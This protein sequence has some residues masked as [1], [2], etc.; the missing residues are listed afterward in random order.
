MSEI[1]FPF[2]PLYL[3]G[4]LPT[5]FVP[6]LGGLLSGAMSQ[7]G[8]L[9]QGNADRVFRDRVLNA[10][11]QLAQQQNALAQQSLNQRNKLLEGLTNALMQPKPS[12]PAFVFPGQGPSF[13][14]AAPAPQRPSGTV[15]PRSW[16]TG[17]RPRAFGA[18][19]PPQAPGQQ[20]WVA[21]ASPLGQATWRGPDLDAAM[22][23]Q[24]Q[25]GANIYSRTLPGLAQGAFGY[26]PVRNIQ[27]A[28]P[29]GPEM[30]LTV[31]A[32][33]GV[34]PMAGMGQATVQGGPLIR[35]TQFWGPSQDAALR[36]R[37]AAMSNYTMPF[38][39]GSSGLAQNF[40]DF[41]AGQQAK[42]YA[43]VSR[44]GTQAQAK[45]DLAAATANQK[46]TEDLWQILNSLYAL[47]LEQDLRD[48]MLA[49]NMLSRLV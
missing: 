9:L 15:R 16:L 30:A 20:T 34:A 39:K 23:Q 2:A 3:S 14:S 13:P 17:S 10:Q 36:A 7:M 26:Q 19:S 40:R 31:G 47:E 43:D 48:K 44:Q 24:E 33:P 46:F 25:A 27:L 21:Q 37:L 38:L 6:N 49:V 11:M 32:P 42:I 22:A 28:G 8:S 5:P 1:V 12:P 4:M 41:L 35:P 45:H 18:M 29:G